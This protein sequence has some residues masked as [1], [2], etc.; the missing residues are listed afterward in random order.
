MHFLKKHS[1]EDM[2]IELRDRKKEINIDE[3]S[4]IC[5]RT[6]DGTCKL[7]KYSAL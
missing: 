3:L 4:P 1:H 2:V 5:A 6:R 7:D